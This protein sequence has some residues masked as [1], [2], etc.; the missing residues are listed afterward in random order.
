[1]TV[2]FLVTIVKSREELARDVNLTV[3]PGQCLVT[4]VR[5]WEELARDVNLTTKVV[6][7]EGAQ[8][9]AGK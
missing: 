3:E 7:Q 8:A 6:R 9:R 5:P 1:M 2:R 4:I